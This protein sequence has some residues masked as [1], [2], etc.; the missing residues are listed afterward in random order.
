MAKESPVER[1]PVPIEWFGRD[2]W[3]TLAY[4]ETVVVDQGGKI[5]NRRMRTDS[6]RH[7][8]LAARPH[9]TAGKKYPTR[10]AGGRLLENHDDWD[11][12]QDMEAAG[13]VTVVLRE[14]RG[15]FF[16]SN[17]VTVGLT[18]RGWKVAAEVREHKGS[19]GSFSSFVR[20][21]RAGQPRET[22]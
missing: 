3:S 21:E 18:E 9:L 20:D 19:G 14:F 13:L 11:C 10:L 17:R 8:T 12:L 4:L 16:N 7:R 2:H 5:D 1:D 22:E 6:R 15:P